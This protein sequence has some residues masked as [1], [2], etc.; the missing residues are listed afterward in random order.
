MADFKPNII[1]P[2]DISQGSQGGPSWLT[3]VVETA[4]GYGDNT[5]RWANT[6]HVYDISYGIRTEAQLY[7]VRQLFHAVRGQTF[8]FKFRDPS[9]N[10]SIDTPDGINPEVNESISNAD[11]V[12]GAGDGVTDGFQLTKRYASFG[13]SYTRDIQVAYDV[14]VAIDG[15]DDPEYTLGAQTGILTF[16]NLS[17]TITNITQSAQ[18]VL[19]VSESTA[20]L[21][22]GQTLYIASV[23]GMTQI[24]D[25]RYTVVAK[26][27]NSI[28]LDVNSTGFT[29]YS[30]G[31]TAKTL[32]QTGESVT[33]GYRFY[34]PV[35]FNTD[36]L[37]IS[38][39][40]F[41]SLSTTLELV[42]I[43]L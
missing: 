4:S 37:N 42:E 5:Q 9:D 12:I 22:V 34:V 26:T 21:S 43:R 3:E 16:E 24:N 7:V 27:T 25:A 6:R 38:Y 40:S 20:S 14:S 29:A 10:N 2:T 17:Y 31:G 15:I 33:A 23:A 18:A 1:F 13:E 41:N 39:E 35:R 28:T 36:R 8:G 19:T 32:P 30:S 11:Q